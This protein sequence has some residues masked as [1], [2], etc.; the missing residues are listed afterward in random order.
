MI[1]TGQ[2]VVEWV[3]KK[4]NE[5]GNFGAST[6]IGLEKDNEL[7]AG[8]VY[9]EWNGPN[10]VM[11]VASDGTKQWLNRE[12]LWFCFAYPFLQLDCKRITG[13]VGEGNKEAIKFDTHVGFALET[14]LE[15]AHPTGNLLIFRM[16]KRDCKWIR[17]DFSKRYAKAA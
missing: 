1:V 13:Y 2:E 8:V 5:F 4:T 7:V 16:W 11:H 17:A 9:A 6:G 10:I 12:Y 15:A 14:T 3:A